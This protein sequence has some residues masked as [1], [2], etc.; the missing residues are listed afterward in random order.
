MITWQQ[1]INLPVNKKLSLR[2]QKTKFLLENTKLLTDLEAIEAM[3]GSA[4]GVGGFSGI[5]NDGPIAGATVTAEGAGTAT[6]DTAGRFTLPGIPTG[7]I[8]Y[9]ASPSW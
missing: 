7:E 4:G 2:E 8:W 6:T 3:Y 5:A 9:D 1:F